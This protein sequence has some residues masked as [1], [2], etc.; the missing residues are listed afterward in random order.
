MASGT[1]TS[2]LPDS[3]RVELSAEQQE[4]V[5]SGILDNKTTS[6]IASELKIPA[7]WIPDFAHKY[8]PFGKRIREARVYWMHSQVERLIGITEGCVTMADVSAAKV[9]SDNIKWSAS[10]IIPQVYGDNI[11]VNITHLDLS[12][13][14]LAAENRVIPLLQAKGNVV[15]AMSA[16]GESAEVCA[17]TGD[18]GVPDELKN[19]V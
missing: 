12:A 6:R 13:V 1:N 15:D 18:S 7:N 4:A 17:D 2:R 5:I 3:I 19:M 10:K 8:P 14:L 9:E 16:A 11:N